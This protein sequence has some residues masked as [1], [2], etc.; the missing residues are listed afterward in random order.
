MTKVSFIF[1]AIALTFSANVLCQTEA[2]Y[3]KYFFF[4]I[5]PLLKTKL[6]KL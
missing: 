6:I 2:T 1:V 4:T 5:L 3:G